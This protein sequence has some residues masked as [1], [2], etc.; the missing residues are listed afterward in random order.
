[1]ARKRKRVL[2]K[3]VGRKNI[4]KIIKASDLDHLTKKAIKFETQRKERVRAREE[5]VR[6]VFVC[7]CDIFFK[8][9]SL[10]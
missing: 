10:F 6:Q 5:K 4:R 2:H 8:F 9:N 1:M 7:I 3:K